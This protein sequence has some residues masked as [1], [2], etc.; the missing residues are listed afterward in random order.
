MA[1]KFYHCPHC[2]NVM[3]K[4]VD[5][6]VT[7]VCCGEPMQ[8]LTPNETD[9]SVEKHVPKVTIHHAV[10]PCHDNM[11]VVKV[12]SEPHPMTTGH[13]INFI[14]LESEHG[15]QMVFLKNGGADDVAEAHFCLYND[16]A[17]TVYAYC[18]LHGL[19]ATKLLM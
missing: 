6:G 5:S 14:Y 8:V 4:T 13:H 15:A 9:A 12:G 11:V 1:T 17:V 2:G 19:W 7:P 18:S 3:V 16:K 10:F